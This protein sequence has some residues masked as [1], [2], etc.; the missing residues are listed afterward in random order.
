IYR[1]KNF[2]IF[3]CENCH[4]FL[5]KER[6][7]ESSVTR[8]SFPSSIDSFRSLRISINSFAENI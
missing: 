8:M 2:D 5:L 3:L 7:S 6:W 4:V 1:L